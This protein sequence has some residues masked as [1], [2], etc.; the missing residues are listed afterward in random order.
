ME[1]SGNIPASWAGNRESSRPDA[2]SVLILAA[3]VVASRLPMLFWGFGLDPDA[4]RIANAAFDLRYHLTYHASRFP[5]YPLCEIMNSFVIGYGWVATNC[6]TM[7]LSLIS[8]V[9]FMQVAKILAI[10]HRTLL[11]LTYAFLPILWINSTNT[12]DYMWAVCFML[13]AWLFTMKEKWLAAGIMMG[14]AIGSRPQTAV[15]IPAFIYL[16]YCISR[17]KRKTVAFL[18]STVITTL[19]L[20]V[21]LV[22]TYGLAFIARYPT[23]T[24]PLEFGYMA[25]RHFGLPGLVMTTLIIP[26]SLRD[27]RRAVARRH[28][29]DVFVMLALVLA[30]VSLIT[31]GGHV[32]YLIIFIPF[33]LIF[34]HRTCRKSLVIVLSVLL[35]SHTFV[36]VGGLKHLGKKELQARLVG[37]GAIANN[38]AARQAQIAYAR[39]VINA[40]IPARSLVI[41]G[42]WLP[43]LAHLDESLSSS[44]DA[45]RMYDSNRPDAGV[46]DHERD[47]EFRYLA[48][49]EE[50]A[51]AQRDDYRIFYL[52]G[53]RELTARAH[54]F[55]PQRYATRLPIE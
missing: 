35:L 54:G 29:V 45:R 23:N 4:W 50:I 26:L 12:M 44:P 10:R 36:T 40:D 49:R 22:L 34:I 20:F 27:V 13:L 33:A 55:D 15:I 30:V 51:A 28:R 18:I 32:E 52:D 5:G 38:I 11:I 6:L 31:M 7:V 3:G 48:D 1:H 25:V 42:T 19:L 47:I 37:P 14:L 17:N 46:R 2:R 41:A 9:A 8:I 16:C 24:G 43:I 53:T 21:P 39:K